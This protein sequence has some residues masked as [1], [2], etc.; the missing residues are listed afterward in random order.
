MGIE[1][2][3]MSR[4]SFLGTGA[5]VAAGAAFARPC[6]LLAFG[7]NEGA[8]KPRALLRP[9][10]SRFGSAGTKHRRHQSRP[11][12]VKIDIVVVGS[13]GRAV[14]CRAHRNR[15]RREAL[16][17]SKEQFARRIT[18]MAECQQAQSV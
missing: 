16:C 1:T 6:G 8:L 14:F 11:T 5:V 10:G 3:G 13:R 15:G 7:R 4:R 12:G 2:K 18:N 17:F 9:A